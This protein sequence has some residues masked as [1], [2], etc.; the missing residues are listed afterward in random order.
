MIH[1]L[2]VTRKMP[3]KKKRK[4]QSSLVHLYVGGNFEIA[5]LAGLSNR[6]AKGQR[7]ENNSSFGTAQ[8]CR[9]WL[10]ESMSFYRFYRGSLLL[11][12]AACNFGAAAASRFN[13]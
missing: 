5:S 2:N 6:T 10:R 7:R 1:R 9:L 8:R 13:F 11:A 12:G 3:E 4:E